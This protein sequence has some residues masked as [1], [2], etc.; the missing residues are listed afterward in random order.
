[1]SDANREAPTAAPTSEPLR[2][3]RVILGVGGG[4]AAYKSAELVRLLTRAGATVHVIMTAAAQQFITPLTLQTL[5]GNP[6]GTELFDLTR[7]SQISHIT[8]ADQAD[9]LLVAPATA[10]LLARLALHDLADDLGPDGA[11]GPGD[12]DGALFHRARHEHGIRRH[13]RAAKEVDRLHAP[14]LPDPAPSCGDERRPAGRKLSRRA[15]A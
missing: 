8:L 7:E 4:I 6:V 1:M 10:D 14:Q 12:E 11:P 9:L 13:R 15:A 3:K 5:S 2:H